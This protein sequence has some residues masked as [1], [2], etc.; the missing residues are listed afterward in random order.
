[1]VLGEAARRRPII[2]GP[3]NGIFGWSITACKIAFR[4]LP[5]RWRQTMPGTEVIAE[6]T[7]KRSTVNSQQSTV[8]SQQ[9]TVNSQQSTVNSQQS[10][11]N[12]Q[13]STC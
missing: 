13:R 6:N 10:T 5:V 8:N 11:V 4:T 2:G 3:E 7:G 1:M 9:S 12:S